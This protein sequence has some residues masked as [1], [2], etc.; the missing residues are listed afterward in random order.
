MTH[1]PPVWIIK[2]NASNNQRTDERKSIQ[3]ANPDQIPS[4]LITQNP[5]IIDHARFAIQRGGPTSTN[6]SIAKF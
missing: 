6:K 2:Y 4:P 3:T 1:F 5:Q